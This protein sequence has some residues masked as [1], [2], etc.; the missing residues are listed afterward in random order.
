MARASIYIFLS[1]EMGYSKTCLKR[2]LK[3]TKIGFQDQLSLNAGQKYCRMLQG[4]HAA[5]LSTFIKLPSVIKIFVLSYFR[6]RLRQVLL[7]LILFVSLTR[8]SEQ[9]RKQRLEEQA[10]TNDYHKFVE[11]NLILKQGLVD[12]RKVS[13]KPPVNSA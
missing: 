6:G 13:I 7:L 3:K 8:I 2:P 1:P 5:I 4:E 12:K 9:E 10:R 11:G